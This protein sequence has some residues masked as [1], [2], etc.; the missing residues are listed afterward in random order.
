MRVRFS[1]KR[2]CPIGAQPGSQTRYCGKRS[3]GKYSLVAGSQWW[4]KLEPPRGFRPG[5]DTRYR[6]KGLCSPELCED[7][8]A[9]SIR[10]SVDAPVQWMP[11]QV[12]RDLA[13]SGTKVSGPDSMEITTGPGETEQN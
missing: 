9:A 10:T 11:G 1:G 12:S 7:V 2:S 13:L 3:V 5:L 4:K 8:D 6:G